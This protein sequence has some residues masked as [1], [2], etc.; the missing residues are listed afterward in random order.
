MY[1]FPDEVRKAYES[2][3]V[4][5]AYYQLIDGRI[6]AILVSDGLCKMMGAERDHL[7]ELLND[8]LFERVHPD[9]AGRLTR[10]VREFAQRLCGY[11]VIYRGKYDPNGDYHYIHSIGRFQPTPDGSDLAV[12]VYTDISESESESAMLVENYTLFQK[13]Q[14]YSDPVT[15][16]PNGNFL[17]EFSEEK[18]DKLRRS[19]KT[20]AIYYFDVNGL[21]SY[22]NQY[23][24]ARG[25][26]LLRLV[27]DVLKGAFPDALVVRGADDHFIL[28]TEFMA[29]DALS[30]RMAQ[31]NDRIKAGAFGNTTGV[32]AGVCAYEPNMDTALA[33]EHARHALKQIGSD[34][35][36]TY[37]LYTPETSDRYWSQRYIVETFDTALKNGWIKIFYQAIMRVKT[38]KAA[39]LEALAR[40]VDPVRGIISP[41]EFIP[42][43]EKYHLL[44]KLD[45]Y[46]AEQLCR[47]IPEREKSG[48]PIIPVSVNFSAQDFD[49]ADIVGS[50]NEIFGRYGIDKENII[51]EITEQDVATATDRFKSQL[52][53][54]RE[55]GFRLWFDDFGSGYSSLNVLS[56]FDVD[57]IKIDLEFLRH[58]DEHGGANR[59]IMK[60]IVELARQLGVRTLVEGME[61]EE[62]LAFLREIGCEFA[63]GFYYFRPEPLDAIRFRVSKGGPSVKCESAQERKAFELDWA[64][65]S[66]QSADET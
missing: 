53:E 10:V 50:L 9:D 51:I 19:G 11:D 37:L 31:V 38:G 18:T 5:L 54:I 17:H 61:T 8:A 33:L 55:N 25:D 2:M 42:V 48:M 58:L 6:R 32:Q 35:N 4:P 21:R 64:E 52:R 57:L 29:D 40:W 39:A 62:H 36:L 59:H 46:M 41:A 49:H 27:A 15:G 26:D 65:Q 34:L 30:A 20:P 1:I 23:G 45:L 60:S 24:Y 43:L 16:L 56:Q 13:D 14:F 44:Y 22:N 7:I 63:Q 3:P 12:F 66:A 28:I 47:E